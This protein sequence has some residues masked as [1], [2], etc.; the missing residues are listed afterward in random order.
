[1]S[2]AEACAAPE[3]ERALTRLE[4]EFAEAVRRRDMEFLERTL[5]EEFTLTTGRPG[6]EIRGRQEWLDVTR[7][8]YV[9]EEFEIE[10]LAV[11][12]YGEAAVVRSRYRQRGRMRD[13]DRSGAY[14]MTDVWARR[15][16][17]WQ[18]VT[19]HISPL[20]GSG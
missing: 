15:G 2:E 4:N 9:V 20:G 1:M 11:H 19:R 7:E 10:P 14:L 17:R 3:V 12:V 6:A 13:R 8:S 18:L 16:D 5:G